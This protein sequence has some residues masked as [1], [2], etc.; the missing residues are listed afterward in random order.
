MPGLRLGSDPSIAEND[1]GSRFPPRYTGSLL[2]ELR[3]QKWVVVCAVPGTKSVLG[4][5]VHSDILS[6]CVSS[7]LS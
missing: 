1:H 5:S 4:R 6:S 2:P 3:S 7:T